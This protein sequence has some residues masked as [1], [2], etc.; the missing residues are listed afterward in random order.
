MI[1]MKTRIDPDDER[2]RVRRIKDDDAIL[3][4]LKSAKMDLA[5]IEGM[6][7][8]NVEKEV[9]SKVY[10]PAWKCSDCYDTGKLMGTPYDKL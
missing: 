1:L 6:E 10:E 8:E 2:V 5:L 7:V 3:D 9:K 4:E